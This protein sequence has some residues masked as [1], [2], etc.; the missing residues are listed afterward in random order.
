MLFYD[1]LCH[2]MSF[3]VTLNTQITQMV[4][5]LVRLAYETELNISKTVA[6]IT[7]KGTQKGRATNDTVAI[8][9]FVKPGRHQRTQVMIGIPIHNTVEAGKMPRISQGSLHSIHAQK[10]RVNVTHVQDHIPPT[11]KDTVDIRTEDK[12]TVDRITTLLLYHEQLLRDRSRPQEFSNT[13]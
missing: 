13:T 7:T 6:Q 1:I 5:G 11:S 4:Q 2:S 12:G 10:Q 3:Y 8:T 9:H